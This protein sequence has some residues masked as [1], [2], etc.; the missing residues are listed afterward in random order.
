MSSKHF[1]IRK[2]AVLGTGVMGTRIAAHLAN[3]DVPVVLF[4]MSEES[5][6]PNADPAK[7]IAGLSKTDRGAFVT[8]NRSAYIDVA[9][10]EKDLDQ[11]GSCDLIIEAVAEDWNIKQDL[12]QK[13]APHIGADGIVASNTSGLSINKLAGLL[14]A[15]SRKNFCGMHFFNPPRYM[16]LVELIPGQQTDP[17]MLD[18]IESW[19]VS[20]LGKSIVR[21]KDT[22]SF[23]ANRIGLF[24]ILAVMHHTEAFGLGLDEVD[25][26]TGRLIE[27]PASATFRTAD[28][29]GLDT[30]ATVMDVQHQTLPDD[31][32]RE[33][34]KAPDWFAGLVAK[35]ALGL[36]TKGGIYRKAGKEIQVLDLASQDYRPSGA[37]ASEEVIKIFRIADPA[38]RFAKL[39]ASQGKHA[40]FLW[41][42]TRDI[43]HYCAYTLSD[44][45]DNVR[46]VDFAMRWG[47]A[48]SVGPFEIWQA[49][50]WKAMAEAIQQD[51]D[52]GKAMVKT[53]LPAWV[54]AR[55]NVYQGGD[56]YS[57]AE[58]TLK[59]RS[60]LPVYERQLF[61]DP[62]VG[63]KFDKGETL[64]EN[65]SMR[66]WRMPK[67]D[68]R[69]AILSFKSKMHALS[70][71]VVEGIHEAVARAEA[72]FDGLVIW[73]PAPFGVGANLTELLAFTEAGNWDAVDRAVAHFQDATKA[74]RYAQVPTVAAVD[75]MA[76]G[77]G[78]EVA[79]HCAHRVLAL[80]SQLG[81]V[82]A[83]V[84]LIP[85]GGGCKEMVR[86]AS[87]AAQGRPQNDPWE[88]IQVAFRNIIRGVTSRG[89]INAREMG[90][91]LAGDIVRFNARELPYVA[92]A[93]ARALSDA[94][95]HPPLR[96]RAI[97]VI[98]APGRA[99][100]RMELVNMREGGFMSAHDY[101]VSDAAATVLCGGDVDPGT[102][103]DED[104]L[105]SLERQQFVAL[106]QTEL[107]Q[108]R[109]T[110][111]LKTGK[112]LRN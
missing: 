104:W 60:T 27:H 35:G 4:G 72:D 84:G 28:M 100:L 89:A 92:I 96:A 73:H 14:P 82:E 107:T 22:Q 11:L 51:I 70:K 74:L 63:E 50:G 94:G 69:I 67:I 83:G 105:L 38:E 18:N 90:Y 88:D 44:I 39:R 102:L 29:I 97:K 16:S 42:A 81:L 79:M 36:K 31:P 77:G 19:L 85:A 9:Y 2:A 64:H 5:G 33:Y 112:P 101:A 40:Q 110:H 48:W 49:A 47:W 66:L 7:A 98:G 80:E 71:D 103:V 86:R 57:P 56:A 17:A 24:S 13:I 32:W 10:Y 65:D 95:Y 15:A 91:A 23:V 55:E 59:G 8:R 6:I 21:A 68:A 106:A 25:A 54:M 53:P 43:L 3:A 45:A 34:F 20:R 78:A 37:K 61:P 52:A 99:T 41:A 93:Q 58:D 87:D 26:L 12:Y 1:F 46:D 108:Q 30:L 76:F 62:I 111:M 109:M 75:G